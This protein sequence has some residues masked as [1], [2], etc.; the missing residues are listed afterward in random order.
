MIYYFSMTMVLLYY[1]VFIIYYQSLFHV[2]G[3]R[4]PQ[5][6]VTLGLV[7]ASYVCLNTWD[8]LLLNFPVVM[9]IMVVGFHFT[10]G[11]N[12][13]QA[14]YGGGTCTITAYCFRGIFTVISS[15]IY[16]GCN[17]LYDAG[18]YYIITILALPASLLFFGALRRTIIPDDKLKKFL[19][20][21]SQLK[22]VVA[23][24]MAAMINLVVI[25]SGRYLSPS[26]DWY[27]EIALGACTL[28]LF[29]LI[30]AIHQSIRSTE[31]LEYQ[32]RTKAL[33]DQYNLQLQHYKSYQKHT[34]SFRTFRHD[35][36][37][38]MG[39]LK[40]FIKANQNDRAIKLLDEI[41]DEMQKK[42]Q[43]HKRYSDNI[44]LDAIL[45]DFSNVCEEKKI[46]FTCCVFAPRST[47]LTLL[48][49]IR[50]FS[51]V[52]S[53]AVEA[54]EKVPISQRFIKITSTHDQRWVMLEVTNSYDGQVII[55]NGTLKT[56]KP[57]KLGH[58]LGLGIVQEIAED[59]GGFII[60]DTD[61][62]NKTFLTRVHIP[63]VQDGES[64][65]L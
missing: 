50:I 47:A 37:F 5:I 12:W 43:I 58:G 23:Y 45:Q 35:Y 25:N 20:N 22:L 31:L 44:T 56:T 3:R 24:Q 32:W 10:T 29:M 19:D 21:D 65:P 59:M 18:A 1:L 4:V 14:A 26:S 38:M 30:F 16:R 41:Y 53:N 11:M 15:F 9:A 60:C 51:N 27:M 57:D 64:A 33:E 46:R 7:V 54:C 40:S 62:E 61:I 8:W 36:K 42:V 13:G 52:T 39:T 17:F 34:E 28:T 55:Q 6:V 63:Y 2:Q 48:N 49:A